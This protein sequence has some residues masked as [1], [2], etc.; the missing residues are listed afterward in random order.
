MALICM[1]CNG[2][3]FK[4]SIMKCNLEELQAC[5]CLWVCTC[6]CVYVCI[7]V[8]MYNEMQYREATSMYVC[9]CMYVR[10]CVCVFMYAY[11]DVCVCLCMLMGMYVCVCM[12]VYGNIH[13]SLERDVRM[14]FI[15]SHALGGCS[16][17]H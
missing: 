6:V 8:C 1:M 11:G 15:H 17:F 5:M 7:W 4:M 12:Y 16:V 10:V 2:Y 14:S 3:I 9:M 13:S